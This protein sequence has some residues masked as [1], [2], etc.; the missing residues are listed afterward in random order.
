VSDRRARLG[1]LDRDF[2]DLRVY[3]PDQYAGIVVLRVSKPDRDRILGLLSRVLLLF[4]Q[5]T[6]AKRLWIVEEHRIRIRRS[7]FGVDD[8]R[9]TTALYP[10]A[11]PT[12][13]YVGRALLARRQSY[14]CGL[15]L[16]RRYRRGRGRPKKAHGRSSAA[17]RCRKLHK[18]P[19]LLATSLPHD[20]RTAQRVV[21]LYTLRMKIEQGI[22]DTKDTRCAVRAS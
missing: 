4:R 11:T 9:Y 19:W 12:P 8:R 17:R 21:K 16:V 10:T 14:Q 18:D 3:P 5:E 2:A 20:A 22:R 13:G 7:L 1:D 15:Y 6:L